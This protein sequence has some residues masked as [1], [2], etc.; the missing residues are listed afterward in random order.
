MPNVYAVI[1]AGGA[2]TRFWPASRARMPKQLLPLGADP[3]ESLI[4]ATVRRIAPLVPPERVYIATGEALFEGTARE[5]P[6]IP[7][8]NL[9]AEPVPRNTAPCIGWATATIARREPDAL[10]MVLPSD[11]FIGD[12]AGFRAVVTRALAGAARGF[13]CT[14]GIVPTRSE[15]GYGYI[16]VGEDL[17]GGLSGV[18]RFVE[19]PEQS[20]AEA[21]VTGGRHLWNAGMFFFAARTMG[22][23]I[24]R[25]LPALAKGLQAIDEAAAKGTEAATLAAIFPGL[26][27]I[28]IDH[29]VMEKAS[30]QAGAVAVVR[31]DFGWNDVGSWESAWELA[32]HDP[33][34]NALP[35]GSVAVDARG[36][37]VRDLTSQASGKPRRVYALVGVSDLVLVETDD[38]VLVIPRS[39]AQDVRKVVEELKAR[40]ELGRV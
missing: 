36:N 25:H 4:A 3:H 14:V 34:G 16:E 10:V 33:D 6:Q 15:T 23:A 40:G 2:G 24:A 9:L 20:R 32:T 1:M 39:R 7:R 11:H 38:A 37:L 13:L 8:Q 17:G 19:K 18:A 31:G 30:S 26:P 12:E 35:T 27:A 22:D 29:G 21:Y 5:L 28:S